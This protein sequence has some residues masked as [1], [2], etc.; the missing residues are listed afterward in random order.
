MAITPQIKVLYSCNLC[1]IK[2]ASVMVDQRE[3][4]EP[5]IMWMNKMTQALCQHHDHR[6][7]QCHPK[8]LSE[9]KIPISSNEADLIGQMPNS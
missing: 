6:S 7:P 2:D 4:D 3:D 9:V 1:G 5:L 8:K